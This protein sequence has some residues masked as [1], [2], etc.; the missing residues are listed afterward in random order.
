MYV[1]HLLKLSYVQ[2][3]YILLHPKWGGGERDRQT[4]QEA[5]FQKIKWL[6]KDIDKN[7]NEAINSSWLKL[8]EVNKKII[9]Y[10]TEEEMVEQQTSKRE[11]RYKNSKPDEV[12]ETYWDSMLHHGVTGMHTSVR[13]C[14]HMHT[15]TPVS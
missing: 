2:M 10:L 9:C 13:V 8:S 11:E 4:E 3:H 6:I 5:I 15:H 14:V 1:S 12:E 7:L